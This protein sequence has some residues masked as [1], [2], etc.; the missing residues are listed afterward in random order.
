MEKNNNTERLI[1]AFMIDLNKHL[2]SVRK[3]IDI[4]INENLQSIKLTK[5]EKVEI[6]YRSMNHDQSKTEC[7]DEFKGYIKMNSKLENIKYGSEEYK[8]IM[9]DFSYVIDLHYK[10]NDHH[11]EHFSNGVNDMNR[12]QKLEMI[13]DWIGS[14]RARNCLDKY[15]QSFDS[16]RIRFCISDEEWKEL[17]SIAE[18]IIIKILEMDKKE[19]V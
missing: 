15:K 16:N 7:F 10:N 12:N 1:V 6:F 8:N 18:E 17:F 5:E 4:L 9:K 11:P 13:C 19:N 3:A 2:E 14:A